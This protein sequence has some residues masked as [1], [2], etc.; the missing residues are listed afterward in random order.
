MIKVFLHRSLVLQLCASTLRR[1]Q[2]MMDVCSHNS[3]ATCTHTLLCK[4]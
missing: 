4:L 1:F 2:G 3:L